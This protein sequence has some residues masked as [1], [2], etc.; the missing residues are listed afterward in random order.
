MDSVAGTLEPNKRA[1]DD[2]GRTRRPDYQPP[3]V[4]IPTPGQRLHRT[5]S[6]LEAAVGQKARWADS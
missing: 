1:E 3:V 4:E 5:L 2:A 6:K